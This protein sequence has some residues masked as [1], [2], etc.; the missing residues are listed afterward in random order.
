MTIEALQAE[1][2]KLKADCERKDDA[3]RACRIFVTPVARRHMGA[4]WDDYCEDAHKRL[5]DEVGT[6]G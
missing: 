5:N 3:L 2:E 4:R 1:N 6:A